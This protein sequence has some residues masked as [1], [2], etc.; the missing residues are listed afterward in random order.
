M[1]NGRV[2]LSCSGYTT[3]NGFFAYIN[4]WKQADPAVECHVDPD[5]TSGSASAQV[6]TG[7]LPPGFD[8]GTKKSPWGVFLDTNGNLIN[9]LPTGASG[10]ILTRMTRTF[11]TNISDFIGETW[12]LKFD[13]TC[14]NVVLPAA[15]NVSRT[16]NR[17]TWTWADSGNQYVHF[18]ALDSGGAPTDPPR[19]IAIYPL[20][21][22]SRYDAGEIFRPDYLEQLSRMSGVIRGMQS[23]CPTNDCW[24]INSF[25][26]YPT[27]DFYAWASNVNLAWSG[28][29]AVNSNIVELH[30][31]T[32]TPIWINIPFVMGCLKSGVVSGGMTFA[33]P[34]VVTELAHE[35]ENGDTVQF[36]QV[37]TPT[38]RTITVTID[39]ATDL[40]TSS[41]T[42]PIGHEVS[43]TTSGGSL[44]NLVSGQPYHIASS[45]YTA[46][47][48]FKL[49]NYHGGSVKDLTGTFS[50]T[51]T[52]THRMEAQ[53]FTVANK[54]SSTYEL[55]GFDASSHGTAFTGVY[56]YQPPTIANVQAQVA[57]LAEYYR[58]NITTDATWWELANEPWLSSVFSQ[59]RFYYTT[60]GDI[61]SDA[62]DG[63]ALRCYGYWSACMMDQIRQTYND[64]SRWKGVFSPWKVNPG[65]GT[66]II[67]GIQAYIDT[68]APA[69]DIT[70]LF[71]HYAITGYIGSG[72]MDAT[73]SATIMGWITT[74]QARFDASLETTK[75]AYFTRMICEQVLDSRHIPGFG[76]TVENISTVQWPAHKAIA[77]AAGL[78]MVQYEGGDHLVPNDGMYDLQSTENK[79]ILLEFFEAATRS[80]N[81]NVL[82]EEM[83]QRWV[84]DIGGT[85]PSQFVDFNV[86]SRFG[87]FAACPSQYDTNDPIASGVKKFNGLKIVAR[88]VAP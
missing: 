59:Y 4:I 1:R 27:T 16:G 24:N 68:N 17:I 28:H 49:A 82:M 66:E 18:Y 83:R 12:V 3:Y 42:P 61:Q 87:S 60:M 78:T 58:D 45:G 6:W 69:L 65:T 46:N 70:D 20:A 72:L 74:S 41:W 48:S 31:Q 51:I 76:E 85:Y 86:V 8:D 29:G 57:L 35:Y 7:D 54:T 34:P 67:E 75:Y 22:E 43:F 10:P 19:N 63:S 50:G 15:T 52:M 53:R 80:E 84:D 40:V 77:D 2:C 25:S 88:P 13:G 44:G 81:M 73:N 64:R 47:T 38:K 71:D 14:S 56:S 33:N 32:Q 23:F 9:P 21:Y 62:I 26:K 39:P 55:S 37:N 5:G 11:A 30:E 36:A 79:A